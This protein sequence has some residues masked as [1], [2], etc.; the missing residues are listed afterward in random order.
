MAARV[1]G[2]G[3]P[4]SLGSDSE[5]RSDSEVEEAEEEELGAMFH[6]RSKLPP[7]NPLK[8]QPLKEAHGEEV[9]EEDDDEIEAL[10]NEG[11]GDEIEDD[12]EVMPAESNDNEPGAVNA[13]STR[14]EVLT[15]E[16][17]SK[18]VQEAEEEIP[19]AATEEMLEAEE[20]EK[21]D[22]KEE[23]PREEEKEGGEGDDEGGA[24]ELQ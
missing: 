4:T 13:E 22:N 6:Q 12:D 2:S 9:L 14:E 8:Q 17:S 15:F 21:K 24:E 23:K 18:D 7:M 19:V 11:V 20:E 5:D 3:S 16:E 10:D 1:G